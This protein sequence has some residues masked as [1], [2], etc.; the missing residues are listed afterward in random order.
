MIKLG[1][2][3]HSTNGPNEQKCVNK[4]HSNGSTHTHTQRHF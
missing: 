3:S 2:T 1:E 4:G